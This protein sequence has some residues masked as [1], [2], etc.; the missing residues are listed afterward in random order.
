VSGQTVPP[1]PRDAAPDA[2][3]PVIP[4]VDAQACGNGNGGTGICSDPAKDCPSEDT[5]WRFECVPGQGET[6]VCQS[7]PK[8]GGQ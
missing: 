5:C 7:F 1:I 3:E 4:I 8:D 6:K 2:L